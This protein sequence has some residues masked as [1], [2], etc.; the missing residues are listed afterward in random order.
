MAAVPGK[1]GNFSLKAVSVILCG[2]LLLTACNARPEDT[3]T[4]APLPTVTLATAEMGVLEQGVRL[5]GQVKGNTQVDVMPKLSGKVERV[6]VAV[7][8]VVKKGD[9]LVQLE[10][11]DIENQIAQ[12]EAGVAAARAALQL[13]REQAQTQILNT[14]NAYA[15]AK[16]GVE[17]AEAQLNTAKTAYENAQADYERVRQLF[18]AGLASQQQLEQAKLGLNQAEAAYKQAQ[19]GYESAKEGLRLARRNQLQAERQTAVKSAE[20]QLQQ[21]EAGLATARQQLEN[22]RITAPVD[23]RVA[24]IRAEVGAM[25]TAGMPV[26][27]IVNM[28]PAIV[29]VSLPENVYAKVQVGQDVEVVVQ[30]ETFSGKVRSKDMTPNATNRAYLLKV[31]VPNPDERL[32]S[33]MT[34][35]VFI[36]DPGAVERLLIPSAAY[37]DST[38][39]GRGRVM[40][41]KDGVVE[42]RTVHVGQMT[43]EKVE[44]LS[45]LQAGEQVVVKGQHLL[46][47][48][49]RVQ[50]AGSTGVGRPS[51]PS[52]EK[53]AE[54]EGAEKS[55][56][57]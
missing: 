19:G 41:Y 23:G 31:E 42:E 52:T 4:E 28:D 11:T 12:A 33:G 29:E 39:P 46:K 40:V 48:G 57:P 21:A 34:A 10:T 50:V 32:A 13:A 37:M 27:T 9:V 22:A 45:G 5:S 3:Q 54:A 26:L 30:G 6:S 38:E 17:Q 16:R 43:T 47:D 25:A 8:D 35:T 56:A 53:E 2:L 49:D 55:S 7:G 18:E 1:I 20:A 15:Q 51:G 24:S 14:A 36:P 44:V